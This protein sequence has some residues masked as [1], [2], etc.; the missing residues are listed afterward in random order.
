MPIISYTKAS[1]GG[2]H[3]PGYPSLPS[4]DSNLRSYLC[5]HFLSKL[6]VRWTEISPLGSPQ[7]DQKALSKFY[8]ASFISREGTRKCSLPPDCAILFQGR[9]RT[10]SSKNNE[11]FPVLS[12]VLFFFNWTFTCLL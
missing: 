11:K 6:Q 7:T 1:M 9:G 3:V 5:C 8:F 4:V 2:F 10:R 12:N